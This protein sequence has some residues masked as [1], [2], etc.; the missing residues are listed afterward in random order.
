MKL[1]ATLAKRPFRFESML[2]RRFA[3]NPRLQLGLKKTQSI[4]GITFHYTIL[5]S[6]SFVFLYPILYIFSRS[7]MQ[8]ADL[9]DATVQ[10]IPKEL[11]FINYSY[12]YVRLDFIKSFINTTMTALIPAVIQMFSCAVI[13][14]GFARYR[15][16]GYNVILALVLF[17]FLVPPQTIVAPLFIFFSDLQWINTFYPFFIPALFGH[18]LRGALFV[19]IFLQFFRGLPHQLEEAALIDGAGAYRTFWT[20]MLPL[21]R[22]AM[23]VVF[24]FSLVWHWNDTF[25]PNLFTMVAKHYNL[26]QQLSVLNGEGEQQLAQAQVSSTV[27]GAAPTNQNRVMAGALLTILPMFILYLFTQRYFVESVERTGIAGD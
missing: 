18:G 3:H 2:E 27:I 20:I 15:F 25:E 19:L 6:L 21:A 14:Y 13:G 9:A 10:W 4:I 8:A 16:P 22:P 17:T 7:M 1:Y 23:L 24:L 5:L 12:A 11:S 26:T